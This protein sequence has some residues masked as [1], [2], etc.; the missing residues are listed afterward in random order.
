MRAISIIAVASVL[1]GCA[2]RSGDIAEAYVSPLQYQGLSCAQIKEEAARSLCARRGRV[3]R[4]RSERDERHDSHNR[5]CDPVLA[6]R[7]PD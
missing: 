4:P 6:G 7:L 5:R 3:G 1:T 2:S